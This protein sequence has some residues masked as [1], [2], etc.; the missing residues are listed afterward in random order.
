MIVKK[1]H[2][3]PYYGDLYNLEVA[4]N[5]NFY[6]D[7]ILVSNCHSVKSY[8]INKVGKKCVN[9]D[10]R[11]GFTGTLHDEEFENLNIYT[12]LGPKIFDFSSQ[13]GI[14]KGVLSKIKIINILLEYSSQKYEM[15]N[16]K[17]QIKQ[18]NRA[19]YQATKKNPDADVSGLKSERS[20]L[21]KDLYKKEVNIIGNS[22][23]R[24]KV[25]KWIFSKIPDG[26]N[27]LILVRKLDHL[28]QL[29]EYL[30][31]NLPDKYKVFV[32]SG[33]VK[34]DV[35]DGIRKVVEENENVIVLATFA[36]MSTGTNVKRLHNVIIGSSMKSEITI[37]QAIGRGLRTHK[38]KEGVI[39]W[40]IVDDLT[41]ND[42]H[43]YTYNHFLERLKLYNKN[44]FKYNTLKLNIE[45]L[46]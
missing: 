34:A 5:H 28:D 16:I 3:F 14:E 41:V 25:F 29:E 44:Q 15:D 11:F 21:K 46:K 26:Q 2:S 30:L 10:Y 37:P 32:I 35:R 7:G 12:A 38:S 40:D 1:V 20:K 19:I 4:D 33:K 9:A 42:K 6:V 31:E 24:N 8:E 22:Q 18:I 17:N 23:D 13:E 39:L 36:T 43:N 27:S 45:N